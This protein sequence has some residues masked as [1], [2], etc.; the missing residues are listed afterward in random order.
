MHAQDWDAR[1]AAGTSW[2]TEPNRWVRAHVEGLAPGRAVDLAAGQGRH[3]VWLASRGWHVLAVD[4]STEAV[5]RGRAVTQA[6]RATGQLAGT[7]DW[8]VADATRPVL[9]PD[10]TDLVLVAY[11]HLPWAALADA[12][13][14]AAAAVAP[15][16]TFLLV[17]HDRTN[18]T[19]GVGGP[20]DPAVLTD[21]RTVA[22]T[23]RASG[24]DVRLAEVAER[25]VE[26]ATR[27][28]RDTLVVA[29]K[30]AARGPSLRPEQTPDT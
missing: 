24:L 28:A 1:Y 29:R 20:Q 6:A 10:S 26:G 27:A 3:A 9:A 4:F 11:L 25:P 8:L 21:A 13:D 12:L 2:G 7:V 19:D 18:L 17:G 5:H 23:L 15:G 16:G 14:H 30:R 22:D